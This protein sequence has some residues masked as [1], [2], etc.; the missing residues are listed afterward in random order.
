MSQPLIRPSMSDRLRHL[1]SAAASLAQAAMAGQTYLAA[2]TVD[3]SADGPVEIWLYDVIDPVWGVDGGALGRQIHA[4]REREV[5]LRIHCYGGAVYEAVPIFEA[6]RAHPALTTRIDGVAM[7]AGAHI[8]QA[9]RRRQMGPTTFQMIHLSWLFAMGDE[10]YLR[11]V[12]DDLGRI[13]RMLLRALSE[14]SSRTESELRQM[15]EETTYLD[16]EEALDAGLVDEIV[17]SPSESEPPAQA[18]ERMTEAARATF[19]PEDA[20]VGEGAPAADEP[21]RESE[22]EPPTERDLVSA[23]ARERRLRLVSL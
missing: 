23:A 3:D 12:A 11:K 6:A 2:E 9:G 22:E 13:D 5:V 18:L 7:S 4:M 16:A 1:P 21:E 8:F 14:R 19:Q 10:P 20:A 15:M 17:E